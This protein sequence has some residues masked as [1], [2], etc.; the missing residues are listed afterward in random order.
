MPRK[1]SDQD[2]ARQLSFRDRLLPASKFSCTEIE[3]IPENIPG[4]PFRVPA[5]SRSS[6]GDYLL[7]DLVLPLEWQAAKDRLSQMD[8]GWRERLFAENCQDLRLQPGEMDRAGEQGLLLGASIGGEDI[9]A[10]VRLDL[11]T[12]RYT[13]RDITTLDQA[14][15]LEATVAQ[16]LNTIQA[17]LG[18]DQQYPYITGTIGKLA[19]ANLIIPEEFSGRETPVTDEAYQKA[20]QKRARQIVQQFGKS[21]QFL[22]FDGHGMPRVIALREGNACNLQ[23]YDG[24]GGL[25]YHPHNIDS[26]EQAASLHGIG[27][28]FI[29]D[30]LG[31]SKT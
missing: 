17:V 22:E 10:A 8:W 11:T 25:S 14:I 27:A 13:G 19:S 3:V 5:I 2:S 16:Y 26:P 23:L 4:H 6:Y 7:T 31:K 28:A 21:I 9:Q 15:A 29:N 18:D 20:F 1:E 12:G 24:F 30:L